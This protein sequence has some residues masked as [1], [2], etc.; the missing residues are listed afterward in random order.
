M[1]FARSP[2]ALQD[3]ATAT[4]SNTLQHLCYSG[5]LKNGLNSIKFGLKRF[6]NKLFYLSFNQEC[7]VMGTPQH[8]SH[9]PHP[10]P[11]H[12]RYM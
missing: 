2:D 8:V 6:N 10:P 9:S 5:P 11:S 3:T 1:R 4:Q 12:L 7:S